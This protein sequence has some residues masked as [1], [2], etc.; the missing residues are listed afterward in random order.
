M[1]I[2]VALCTYNGEKFLKNQ[3]DSI[4]NQTQKVDEIVVC[5]DGS[6]DKTLKIIEDYSLTFPSL[7]SVYKNEINLRSVKNFEKAIAVTSGDYIFL[8]DQDDIW[9]E[10]KVEKMINHFKLN[11]NCLGLFSDGFLIQEN[12]K[13]IPRT[14]LWESI[15]FDTK[16]VGNFKNLNSYLSF[17][18][19]VVTG[20]ALCIKKEA[21]D[22]IFP[23][24]IVK[25][26]HHDHWIAYVLSL[27][28]ELQFIDK[29]LIQYRLHQNQQVGTSL[30]KSYFK[31]LKNNKINSILFDNTKTSFLLKSKVLKV[32]SNNLE[33]YKSLLEEIENEKMKT[34][35]K[36]TIHQISEKINTI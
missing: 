33:L 6:T 10:N 8:A 2:S 3:I 34:I 1:K 11:P 19:N 16:Q 24:P 18:R 15:Y 7:F 22:F 26:F 14:S 23:F 32:L 27:K 29:K 9:V 31:E 5:D 30:K 36:N 12:N 25:G 17:K 28:N 13:I 20:A 35:I 4:L 21:K